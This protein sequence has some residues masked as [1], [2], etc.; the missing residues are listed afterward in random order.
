MV[1][2]YIDFCAKKHRA[3]FT[4]CFNDAQYFFFNHSIIFLSTVEFV[5]VVR[6]RMIILS[7]DHAQLKITCISFDVKGLVTI[8]VCKKGVRS[9][10]CF[11]LF[12]CIGAFIVPMKGLGGMKK[13][14]EGCKNVASMWPHVAIVGNEAKKASKL[15]YIGRGLHV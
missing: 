5:S 1:G 6:D 4:K 14:A 9:D 10:E 8:G 7:D 2:V 13:V 11:H 12:E 3:E 15:F